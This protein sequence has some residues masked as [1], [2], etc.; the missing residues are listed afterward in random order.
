MGKPQPLID[1]FW[2]KV[3]KNGPVIKP[4]LGACWIWKAGVIYGGYGTIWEKGHKV[5]AH[6]V[7]YELKFGPVPKGLSVLHH[8]DNPP[9]V[10]PEHLFLGTQQSNIDDMREKGRQR[11][12]SGEQ[13]GSSKLTSMQV[14]EI[15]R[16]RSLGELQGNLAR[17]FHVNQSQ[18]SMIVRRKQ[19]NTE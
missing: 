16:R 6:R 14:L 1:R 8:C 13:A 17:E 5:G 18:I 4:E 15:R 12:V 2:A 19:R 9:C 3:D 7:S 11:Y 10:R